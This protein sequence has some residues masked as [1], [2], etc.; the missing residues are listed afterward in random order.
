M[1]KLP[2]RSRV[3]YRCYQG[4][5]VLLDTPQAAPGCITGAHM[6]QQQW[7]SQRAVQRLVASW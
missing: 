4:S 3:P 5:V 7:I 2:V 1:E 6:K